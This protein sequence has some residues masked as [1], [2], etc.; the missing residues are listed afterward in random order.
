MSSVLLLVGSN[1]NIWDLIKKYFL[2]G[3]VVNFNYEEGHNIEA[4]TQ[5]AYDA[6]AATDHNPV[7]GP[8]SWT[9]PSEEGVTYVICGVG[10]HCSLGNQKIAITTSNSC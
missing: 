7:H 4:V 2:I 3:D 1:K 8:L 10:L 9:A 6:C 5:E